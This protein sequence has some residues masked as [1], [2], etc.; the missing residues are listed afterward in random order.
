MVSFTFLRRV[1]TVSKNAATRI[2]FWRCRF[3][4]FWLWA[5]FADVKSIEICRVEVSALWEGTL[6]NFE[7]VKKL[8]QEALQ[9]L[10]TEEVDHA[11]L[12]QLDVCIVS[13]RQ[14]QDIP[15]K[16]MAV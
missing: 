1:G 10:Q 13:K 2:I 14:L 11:C 8:C 3:I 6:E 5:I 16:L 12:I 7:E 4:H 15:G 9:V